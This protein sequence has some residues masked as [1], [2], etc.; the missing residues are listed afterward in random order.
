MCVSEEHG[1]GGDSEDGNNA[2]VWV[3]FFFLIALRKSYAEQFPP[4]IKSRAMF[5]VNLVAISRLL[6]KGYTNTPPWLQWGPTLPCLRCMES[7]SPRMGYRQ[8]AAV[9][10]TSRGFHFI[11]A[12]KTSGIKKRPLRCAIYSCITAPLKLRKAR[13][14]HEKQ[15]RDLSGNKC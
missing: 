4:K 6:S 15:K 13:G 3:F 14:I 7:E 2:A 12:E 1:H 11:Q 5:V 9:T 8:P 10:T